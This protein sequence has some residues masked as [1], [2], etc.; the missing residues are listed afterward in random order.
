LIQQLVQLRPIKWKDV[1]WPMLLIATALTLMGIMQINS[2]TFDTKFQDSWWKQ[3][4]FLG[5]GLVMFVAVSMIDYHR[6]IGQAYVMYGVLVGSLILTFF[7]GIKVLGARRWLP[8]PGGMQLQVSEFG[9]IVL[10]LVVAR[11]LAELKTDRLSWKDLFKLGGLVAV[12]FLLVNRQPDLGTSL[13]YLPILGIGILLAGLRWQQALVLFLAIAIA[14]PAYWPLMHEYQR[15]RIRTFLNP[16]Q[17]PSDSGYQVIQSKIA[18]GSGGMTGKGFRS[19]TQTQLRFLPISHTDFIFATYAE[20]HGFVGVTVGLFLFL[21]L[22]M[23]I[24]QN[25]QTAPDR[26]GLVIC[27]SVAAVLLFH[28]L[29][30]VGMVVGRM[31]VTGIPLPLMSNGGSNLWSVFLMLGLV[32]NVRLRRY[33]A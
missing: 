11:F 17:D 24:V 29:V 20:E 15:E 22:L 27:M 8:L 19:G 26:S 12:P 9:K 2:A 14:I 16:E 6:L 18:V 28:I 3:M 1:D 30:N 13:T 33:L 4:I 23:Q 7:V 32:N 31:P 25:A 10:I 21:I 5:P